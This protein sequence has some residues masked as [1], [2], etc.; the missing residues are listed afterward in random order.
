M[1]MTMAAGAHVARF[2]DR[3]AAI[4]AGGKSSRMGRNKALLD[5][6]G[7]SMV[8]RTAALLR[9]LV[10]DLF[11]VADDAA[12]YASLG[13]PI[14]PD[15][16][17]GC[18]SLG[19]IHAAIA[20]AAHPLVLCVACDMP[21][22]AAAVPELLLA[23]AGPDDDALIPRVGDRPEPLLAVY[24]RGALPAMERAIIAGRLRIID[25][26]RG[27]RVRFLDEERI[28]AVDPSLRS[29]VNVNTP[30]QLTAARALAPGAAP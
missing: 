23:S 8:R 24:G 6:G 18:G 20:G 13:L 3:S 16:H 7:S 27:L 17:H 2:P 10:D 1:T 11:L 25:A 22:L 30:E 14:L 19:G 15:V 5:V 9:P 26:I 21:H 28:R 12:P 29:F 4:L